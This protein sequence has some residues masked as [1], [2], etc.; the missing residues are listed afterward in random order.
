M[1]VPFR[2]GGLLGSSIGSRHCVCKNCETPESPIKAQNEGYR[3][4]GARSIVDI[5]RLLLVDLLLTNTNCFETYC[6]VYTR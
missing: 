2:K 6:G 4:C 1:I 3:G 5:S